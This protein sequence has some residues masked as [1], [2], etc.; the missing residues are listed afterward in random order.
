MKKST[1][2]KLLT[3]VVTGIKEDLESGDITAIW[4]L[5]DKTPESALISFLTE[6]MWEEFEDKKKTNKVETV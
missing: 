4:E 6:E 5:L 3:A 2:R 1:K